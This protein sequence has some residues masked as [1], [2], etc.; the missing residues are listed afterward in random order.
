MTG[1]LHED[2]FTLVILSLS[3]SLSLNVDFHE[4]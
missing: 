4:I 3:L 1:T 2:L